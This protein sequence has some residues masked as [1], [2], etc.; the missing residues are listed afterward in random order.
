MVNKIV[1][2]ERG[3]VARVVSINGNIATCQW[4]GT[5]IQFTAP[6]SS[7]RLLGDEREPLQKEIDLEAL[8]SSRNAKAIEKFAKSLAPK[9]GRGRLPKEETLFERL[10]KAKGTPEFAVLLKKAG[11]I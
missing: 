3:F 5:S 7:L 11:L 2:T 10:K 4:M 9:R 6:A 8:I 1:S